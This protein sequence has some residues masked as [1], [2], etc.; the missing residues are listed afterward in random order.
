MLDKRNWNGSKLIEKVRL[1]TL[2]GIYFII[3]PIMNLLQKD[4]TTGEIPKENLNLFGYIVLGI[5]FV[6]LLELYFTT[7]IMLK[8]AQKYGGKRL[9]KGRIDLGGGRTED[10][11][12]LIREMFAWEETTENLKRHTLKSEERMFQLEDKVF[13]KEEEEVING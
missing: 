7:K 4:P 5:I 8:M 6:V 3:F 1:G 10:F 9:W 12:W 13:E 2:L 11:R